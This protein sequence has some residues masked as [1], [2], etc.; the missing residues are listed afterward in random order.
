MGLG[1]AYGKRSNSE[2]RAGSSGLKKSHINDVSS[3]TT[4]KGRFAKPPPPAPASE[5]HKVTKLV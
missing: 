3:S 5:A 2:I 1:R 4:E